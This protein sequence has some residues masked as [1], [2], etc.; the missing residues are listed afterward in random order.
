MAASQWPTILL[1]GANCQETAIATRI[2]EIERTKT[3]AGARMIE[4]GA[5][6]MTENP[7]N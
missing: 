3:G 4:F 1:F 5:E 6:G 7:G 2:V